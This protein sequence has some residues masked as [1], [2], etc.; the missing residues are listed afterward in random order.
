MKKNRSRLCC[1]LIALIALLAVT[2]SCV[3]E[4]QFENS[5]QGNFE[6]CWKILDERYCFFAYKEVDWREVKERYAQRV[7]PGMT[8]DSLFNLL[9][10]MLAELKD[11]HVNLYSSF[12]VARYWKWFEDYPE[13]FDEKIQKNYLGTNYR[14]AGGMRY[15]KLSN[16]IG[17]V[18]YGSFNSATGDANLDNMLSFFANCKGLIIDVRD[19]G[20]GYL[21]NSTKIAA[22]FTNKRVSAGFIQHKRGP[23]HT[24]FSELHPIWLDPSPRLRWDKQVVVL[25]NRHTYSA[26]N[27]FV[28][29]MRTL[30]A[31]TVMG[32]RTGG[33]SGMPA[34]SELPIGWSLRYSA[35]P[36]YDA[37]GEHT[38]FGIDPDI[39]VAMRGIDMLRGEDTI[40]EEAKKL[41]SA[42]PEP[43]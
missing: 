40:I 13:N 9:G 5:G 14:I 18:Y 39:S 27:N 32:D 31:V 3:E 11:G 12:N 16:E 19:N 34:S 23:G 41:I 25:T 33:G 30:P 2:T 38:E 10:E 37:A 43:Q 36:I 28:G 8:Q 29:I 4:H 24:D 22:R 6:A 15:V 7:G 20:G 17:Y 21:T 26:A 1:G 42:S 35:S